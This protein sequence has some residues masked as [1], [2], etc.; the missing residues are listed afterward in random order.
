MHRFQFTDK[1]VDDMRMRRSSNPHDLGVA[2]NFYALDDAFLK[3]KQTME[4]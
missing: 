3:K 4:K 1:K 2:G